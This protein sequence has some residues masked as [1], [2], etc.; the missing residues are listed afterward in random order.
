[1]LVTTPMPQM[2]HWIQ[3]A[4]RVHPAKAATSTLKF[5][6]AKLLPDQILGNVYICIANNVQLTN[7]KI[8]DLL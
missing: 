6:E 1:M 5:L 3:I 7:N 2:P 8:S 4:P